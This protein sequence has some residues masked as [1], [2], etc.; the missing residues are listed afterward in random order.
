MKK[1]SHV[2]GDQ[3]VISYELLHVLYWLLKYEE[4]ELSKLIN[5]SFS[6]GIKEKMKKHDALAELQLSEEMQNS[7]VDFF[8]FMEQEISDIT[9]QE[10]TKL[11]NKEIIKDLDHFDPKQVDY[12]TVKETISKNA[13][14]LQT[15]KYHNKARNLFLKE[16]L[17]HWTPQKEK[18]KKALIN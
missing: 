18:S 7:I 10:T 17:R 8:T 16:L 15:K 11:I 13:L 4:V 6:K 2:Q 1:N 3:F 5:K 12:S 14:K 9:D